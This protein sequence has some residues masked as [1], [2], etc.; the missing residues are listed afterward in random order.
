MPPEGAKWVKNPQNRKKNEKTTY[1]SRQKN[2]QKST[3]QKNWESREA[4]VWKRTIY[5]WVE[6][7]IFKK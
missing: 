1:G 7:Q 3:K 2:S 5:H 4:F 6:N